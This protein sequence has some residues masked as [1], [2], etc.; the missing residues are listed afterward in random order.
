MSASWPEER[1]IWV[2][3]LR[4]PLPHPRTAGRSAL[5]E[6]AGRRCIEYSVRSAE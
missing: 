2:K 4:A 1:L 5:K 6:E 3:A